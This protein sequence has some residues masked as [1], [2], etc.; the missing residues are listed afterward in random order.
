MVVS[1]FATPASVCQHVQLSRQIR[2]C[3]TR[4]MLGC[5]LGT[6]T[7]SLVTVGSDSFLSAGL[8]LLLSEVMVF[9]LAALV[10]S[11]LSDLLL[12]FLTDF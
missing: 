5:R 8:G 4:P 1:L 6:K 11:V 2:S 7:E 12:L 10:S 3:E 9:A